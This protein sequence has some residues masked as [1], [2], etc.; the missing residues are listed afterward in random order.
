[1][2]P[3]DVSLATTSS[4]LKD[5]NTL[6]IESTT[7]EYHEFHFIKKLHWES[8]PSRRSGTSRAGTT[9]QA[10]PIAAIIVPTAR[11]V[12]LDLVGDSG[13]PD[14]LG[15][16]A[17]QSATES[18]RHVGTSTLRAGT[19]RPSEDGDCGRHRQRGGSEE[20]GSDEDNVELHYN[21][22]A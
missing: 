3:R 21:E 17:S 12:E 18:S 10:R 19:V 20:S 8:L 14:G 4:P 6:P 1:M 13:I 5:S 7:N 9:R 11:D 15:R 16:A 2:E 22:M